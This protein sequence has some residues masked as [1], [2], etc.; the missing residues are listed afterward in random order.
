MSSAGGA[1]IPVGITLTIPPGEVEEELARVRASIAEFGTSI[2]PINVP[3]AVDPGNLD[4]ARAQ[5]Q[6]TLGQPITVP[7][8]PDLSAYGT[9]TTAADYYSNDPLGRQTWISEQIAN[10]I[11]VN[12]D[13][14]EN[15]WYGGP[16]SAG[17]EGLGLMASETLPDPAM[18]MAERRG[19]RLAGLNAAGADR[20]AAD[21]AARI[22]STGNPDQYLRNL[23]Y[24]IDEGAEMETGMDARGGGG[25]GG[26]MGMRGMFGAYQVMHGLDQLMPGQVRGNTPDAMLRSISEQSHGIGTDIMATARLGYGGLMLGGPMGAAVGLGSGI[27]M[28]IGEDDGSGEVASQ[29]SRRDASQKQLMVEREYNDNL[30]GVSRKME[31]R[32]SGDKIQIAEAEY[33]DTINKL[34]DSA[35]KRIAALED[36]M[37]AEK[38][39]GDPSATR[40]GS[41]AIAAIQYGELPAALKAADDQRVKQEAD[42]AKAAQERSEEVGL[43]G[44]IRM[45]KSTDPQAAAL[46]QI[47]LDYFNMARQLA[48]DDPMRNEL[49]AEMQD[50]IKADIDGPTFGSSKDK[51]WNAALKRRNEEVRAGAKHYDAAAEDAR[52][53]AEYWQKQEQH[54]QWALGMDD[55]VQELGWSGE[56]RALGRMGMKGTRNLLEDLTGF[57]RD[58]AS[59][60]GDPKYQAAFG[61]ALGGELRS[62][63]SSGDFGEA[64]NSAAHLADIAK[65]TK[66]GSDLQKAV[67]A[68]LQQMAAKSQAGGAQTYYLGFE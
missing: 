5:I 41:A 34:K 20:D 44:K 45:E 59:A 48:P 7:V 1:N 11:R 36:T 47:H 18:T 62:G 3:I 56:S 65:N 40:V 23:N 17:A 55:R 12:K 46:D 52:K 22:E 10:Q 64:S 19:L 28:S 68:I 24:A 21:A 50:D 61:Q 35:E 14:Q 9:A 4:S 33:Q 27:G 29:Q 13:I 30:E 6:N 58:Y 39:A 57:E 51:I 25:M 8:T 16:D 42:D 53:S 60:K 63:L 54:D 67:V 31:A 15:G 26:M 38:L 43:R 32:A 66:D 37:A 2:Q 49:Y